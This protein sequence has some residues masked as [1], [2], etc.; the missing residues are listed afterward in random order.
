TQIKLPRRSSPFISR[1]RAKFEFSVTSCLYKSD[2]DEDLQMVS[3]LVHR[4]AQQFRKRRDGARSIKQ[5]INNTIARSLG[6]RPELL[7]ALIEFFRCSHDA[8]PGDCQPTS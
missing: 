7:G 1:Q 8:R 4:F 6:E 5:G 3:H 2:I